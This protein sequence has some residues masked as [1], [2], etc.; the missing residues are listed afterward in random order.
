MSERPRL[1]LVPPNNVVRLRPRRHL[2]VVQ[3]GRPVTRGDCVDGP[4]PCPWQSCRHHLEAA[5]HSCSLDLADRG[6]LTLD[7]VGEVFG[8]T[9]ERTR[10]IEAIAIAKLKR[11]LKDLA[12]DDVDR[13]GERNFGT[14]KD[15]IGRRELE[16]EEREEQDPDDDSTP[17]LAWH[18]WSPEVLVHGPDVAPITDHENADGTLSLGSLWIQR[19][20]HDRATFHAA[21]VVAA[22]Y[23][24]RLVDRGLLVRKRTA[25]KVSPFNAYPKPST[26]PATKGIT[27]SKHDDNLLEALAQ[28]HCTS[29]T[30]AAFA[31]LQQPNTVAHL[32]ALVVAGK[33]IAVGAKSQ[34]RYHL[35]DAPPPKSATP[36]A[37]KAKAARP[38]A[39]PPVAKAGAVVD[40]SAPT[41]EKAL[42]HVQPVGD[43]Y[44]V[45][46][47]GAVV[48]CP[49]AR[50]AFDLLLLAQAHR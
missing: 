8:L 25:P 41:L 48:E 28:G 21:G 43:G 42:E 32:K 34:R 2:E 33:V 36:P 22:R 23:E 19:Q 1:R 7:L 12:P 44:R 39:S 27:M 40:A 16:V 50:A 49:N 17:G 14:G 4:R 47:M 26:R 6:A 45:A 11:R 35:P 15:R 31:G 29:A 30:V 9:R 24:Q 37:R 38:K 46:L 5:E 20:G 3:P 10:Q 18:A 13:S